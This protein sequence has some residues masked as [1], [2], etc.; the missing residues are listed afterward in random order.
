MPSGYKIR[1]LRTA[2]KNL[3]D[4][5]VYIAR[6]NPQA[7]VALV[8]HILNM[9]DALAE[10]PAIGRPG[11]VPGTR[12]LIITGTPCLIPYRAKGKAVEILRVF[13]GSRRWPSSFDD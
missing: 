6:D 12:E 8:K 1:W 7:A 2:L 3:D 13:H 9:V 5:A 11:R 4:E 10:H